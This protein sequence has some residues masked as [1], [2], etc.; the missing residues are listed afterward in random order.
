MTILSS[1]VFSQHFFRNLISLERT[2]E[3]TGLDNLALLS[4]YVRVV[5]G[6]AKP[7]RTGPVELDGPAGFRRFLPL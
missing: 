5:T 4:M 3:R 2:D 6:P 7:V 1:F